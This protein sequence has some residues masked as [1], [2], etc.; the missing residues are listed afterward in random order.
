MS[1][2]LVGSR[3]A[4]ATAMPSSTS[5]AVPGTCWQS[6]ALFRQIAPHGVD[7]A[8]HPER[9]PDIPITRFDGRSLPFA[10]GTFDATMLCYVLHHL[11]PDDAAALLA[12]VTRV[13]RRKVFLIEDSMPEFSAL[14]RLRNQIHR[15]EAGL[16][17]AT[18]SGS[19]RRPSDEAM[20]LTHEGWRTW[21]GSQ[22]RVAG[23]E[24][25][26]FADISQH[27][28]HTLLDVTLTS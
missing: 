10:D 28:H 20:F 25:E 1:S 22:P 27:D 8:L 7:L 16:R 19:Y 26:S 24:V 4:F 14:Y 6:F 3:L 23:V 15:Y 11:V 9:F 2:R 21:L 5:A 13:T 17:Y 18:S 12:E